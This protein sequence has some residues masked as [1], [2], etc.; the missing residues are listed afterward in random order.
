VGRAK[1]EAVKLGLEASASIP[2][3]QLIGERIGGYAVGLAG[4]AADGIRLAA[5]RATAEQPSRT[6][7][8]LGEVTSMAENGAVAVT[9]LAGVPTE[10]F[11]PKYEIPGDPEAFE[12]KVEAKISISGQYS[13]EDGKWSFEVKLEYIKGLEVNVGVFKGSMKK[14]KR[15]IRVFYENGS[16]GVE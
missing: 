15:L 14:G 7:Q 9:Q 16:W 6:S 1:L 2:V 8:N 3:S 13:V 10:A 5:R 4:A 12:A 11:T